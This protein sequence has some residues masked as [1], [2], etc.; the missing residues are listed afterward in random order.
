MKTKL[1]IF[2]LLVNSFFCLPI[3]A[4]TLN[5]A[6]ASNFKQTLQA[7]KLEFEKETNHSI[8][9]ITASTGQ[10][11]QQISH[12]APFDILLAANTSHPQTLWQ[13]I[14]KKRNL[15]KDALYTY[16]SGRLVFY[17]HSPF[18]PSDTVDKL[19]SQQDLGKISI[20]NPLLAPYGLAAKQTLECYKQYKNWKNKIVVGQNIAQAYQFIDSQS[21]NAGFVAMSQVL[22]KNVQHV[23]IVD[24]NC[25]QP[26]KQ[27]ALRLNN[28]ASSLKFWEFLK[29]QNTKN[30]IE[31]NGYLIPN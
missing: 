1:I 19:L 31:V 7:I 15:N 21:V 30:I 17:S 26:I 23:K 11:F 28:K 8:R 9:I 27:T 2:T 5:V 24:S 29:S 6:V 14:H 13:N 16:A 3:Q 20:A 18:K 12:G 25:Y 10:L 22:D 4:D